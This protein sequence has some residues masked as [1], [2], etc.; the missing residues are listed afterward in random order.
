MIN[1]AWLA[2]LSDREREREREREKERERERERNI[3]S[4]RTFKSHFTC[5]GNSAIFKF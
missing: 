5:L 3:I 1:T 4:F 2:T